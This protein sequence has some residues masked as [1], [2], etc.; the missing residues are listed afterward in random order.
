MFV[1]LKDRNGTTKRELLSGTK[2]DRERSCSAYTRC[3]HR[4]I[5]VVILSR[6]SLLLLPE[7]GMVIT[8]GTKS[9]MGALMDY[10]NQP[11]LTT[12]YARFP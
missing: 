10:R 5:Q 11:F 9:D 8:W 1:K 12:P 4:Q 7:S 3:L 6:V 2:V